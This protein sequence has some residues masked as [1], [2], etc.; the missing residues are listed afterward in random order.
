MSTAQGIGTCLSFSTVAPADPILVSDWAGL[1][2]TGAAELIGIGEI[3]GER[4]VSSYTR[5]CDGSV[6][7]SLGGIDNGQQSIT[8]AFDP[9][10]AGQTIL[11]DAFKNASS[12]SV[13]VKE[14]LSNG[15]IFY[16][17]AEVSKSKVS[18]V[19]GEIV[20]WN[21]NLEVSGDILEV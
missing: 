12:Q 11:T 9:A 21:G 18:A 8:L 6:V 15:H 3:G 5:L 4:S 16:Y 2:W 7:K 19:G 14:T 17:Q 13:W 1:A 20:K 10:D